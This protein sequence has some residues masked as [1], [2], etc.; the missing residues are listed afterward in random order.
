MIIPPRQFVSFMDGRIGE[1]I[2]IAELPGNLAAQIHCTT[3]D[4]LIGREYARKIIDKHKLGYHHFSIIQLAIDRGWCRLDFGK[5]QFLYEDNTRY[6]TPFRLAIKA[7]R[8]GTELWVATLHKCR[9]S[10]VTSLL[11]RGDV[12]RLHCPDEFEE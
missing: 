5:L 9:R 6:D 3:V 8:Q 4:V 1:S 10:Q 12:L 7:A 2:R 11:S